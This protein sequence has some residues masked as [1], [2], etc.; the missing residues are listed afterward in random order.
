MS[1]IEF[2]TEANALGLNT[3][4]LEDQTGVDLSWLDNVHVVSGASRL[5]ADIAAE[6]RV[7]PG[8]IVNIVLCKIIDQSGEHPTVVLMAGD[9]PC[10]AEQVPRA[11]N[12]TGAPVSRLTNAE[13]KDLTGAD[14]DRLFT[15]PLAQKWP[16]VMDASLQRF[17]K[18]YTRAGGRSCLIETSY[19]ELKA[20]T[21][22]L[23]SYA[24]APTD[25]RL[26]T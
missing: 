14:A 4:G 20:L 2:E 18:L 3:P 22:A 10:D 24:L 7:E 19:G 15:I 16:T 6:M 1:A 9:M 21:G 25:W 13:I 23:V 11:L 8:A 12:L 26:K 17:D 5:C